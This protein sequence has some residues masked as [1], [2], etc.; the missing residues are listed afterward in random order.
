MK[1]HTR[2]YDV[3]PLLYCPASKNTIADSIINEK[4]GYNYSLALC[5]EDTINDDKVEEAENILITSIKKIYIAKQTMDFSMPKLFIRIRSAMQIRKL[6]DALGQASD[7]ISGFIIPKFSIENADKYIETIIDVNGT[8]RSPIYTMPI[9]ESTSIIN[10]KDRYDILYTLKD[11]L[12]AIEELVLNIR[13]GGNDLCHTFGFRRHVD[14]S[15]HQISPIANIFSDIITVYG[16]DYVI[17]GP[18]WEYYNG[19]GWKEGLKKEIQDDILCGFT[20]KTVIHP[21]QIE[22]VNNGFKVF[23][24]DYNDAKKILAWDR[25]NTEMV[26]ASSDNSRMNE[27]KTHHIWAEKIL[28]LAKVYGIK[29]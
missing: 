3:G 18:V 28:Y 7:I 27:Y 29:E 14:E 13:V 24:S 12:S 23:R 25:N 5:L 11:K 22:V 8:A 4:L 6:V 10:L 15:I 26:L 20:G 9:Y 19:E 2:Y 17:S 1:N 21:N 16:Q